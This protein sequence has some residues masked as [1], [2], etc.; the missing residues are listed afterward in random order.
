MTKSILQDTICLVKEKYRLETTPRELIIYESIDG[1]FPF[2]EW[3][4][5]LR[6]IAGRAVIRKRLNRV[7][8]GNLGDAKSVGDG[9]LE[10]R[11][12]F[13]PG[14]RVYFSEDGPRIVVLLCGGDKAT[15]AKDIE[16]AKS[17]LKNYRET[18]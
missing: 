14:Y 2:E 4:S 17:Y 7:R 8:L 11:I 9:V 3:L 12:D 15:Q 13:G 18:K 5:H 10:L 16:Q 6:D 1:L